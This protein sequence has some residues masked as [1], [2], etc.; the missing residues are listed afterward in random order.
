MTDVMFAHILRP[1][2][3]NQPVIA[4]CTGDSVGEIIV[5]RGDHHEGP[6]CIL[7]FSL[8]WKN[9]KHH[10]S[11]FVKLLVLCFATIGSS[12]GFPQVPEVPLPLAA[13]RRGDYI[14]GCKGA[15]D[16]SG[17]PQLRVRRQATLATTHFCPELPARGCFLSL[18]DGAAWG[19]ITGLSCLLM[20]MAASFAAWVLIAL[21][22]QHP[23]FSRPIWS[24]MAPRLQGG[25]LPRRH[26]PTPLRNAMSSPGTCPTR[27]SISLIRN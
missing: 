11:H 27:S 23:T 18:S 24:R 3:R 4:F 25:P 10:D 13:R 14:R 1:V 9:K 21:S 7:L 6:P 19:E 2:R 12:I 8:A 26:P 22:P 20:W 5:G 16:T 17:L 15:P